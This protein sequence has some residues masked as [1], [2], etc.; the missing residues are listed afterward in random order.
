MV[1]VVEEGRKRY[2]SEIQHN[3]YRTSV[4][5]ACQR[6]KTIMLTSIIIQKKRNFF[7]INILTNSKDDCFCRRY[8]TA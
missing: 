3:V 5:S 6:G 1:M 2:K 7:T 4:I 8:A